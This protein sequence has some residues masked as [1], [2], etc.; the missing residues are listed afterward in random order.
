VSR[1]KATV[2]GGE[3]NQTIETGTSS[4]KLGQKGRQGKDSGHNTKISRSPSAD[5]PNPQGPRGTPRT[6]RSDWWK[7]KSCLSRNQR[8]RREKTT[9]GGKEKKRN[10]L[11]Q[12]KERLKVKKL[13]KTKGKAEIGCTAKRIGRRGRGAREKSGRRRPYMVARRL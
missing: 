13:E 3:K 2:G 1:A 11:F 9:N 10:G 12:K 4:K 5:K 6:Q 7:P 8:K